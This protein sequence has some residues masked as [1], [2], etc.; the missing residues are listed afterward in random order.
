MRE[1]TLAT[2]HWA[3]DVRRQTRQQVQYHTGLPQDIQGCERSNE[4]A[5][6]MHGIATRDL[7]R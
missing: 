2:M 5:N 3:R 4:V 6:V 7:T 1:F